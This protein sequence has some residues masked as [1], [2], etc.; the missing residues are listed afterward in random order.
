MEGLS[1]LKAAGYDE[2]EVLPL[3]SNL[4][5]HMLE[6]GHAKTVAQLEQRAAIFKMQIELDHGRQPGMTPTD[7]D[8]DVY[9]DRI[10]PAL[11]AN[12]QIALRRGDWDQAGRSISKLLTVKPDDARTY[13][14]KGEVQR[15][16]NGGGHDNPCIGSYKKALKIDPPQLFIGPPG[17]WESCIIKPGRY[18]MA[19]PYFETFLSLAPRDK[20]R[21]FIKGYLRQCQN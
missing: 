17:A 4:K 9:H 13:Y 5:R 20:A 11:M 1:I 16:Q 14:L 8:P 3:I 12:A 7:S 2:N 19:K 21:E 15:R 10:A 6:Q 18:R